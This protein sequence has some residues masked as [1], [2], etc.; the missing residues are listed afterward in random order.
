MRQAILKTSLVG[1][2]LA[3]LALPPPGFAEQQDEA[4]ARARPG[5][6]AAR[7]AP[8]TPIRTFRITAEDG[9]IVP[10]HIRAKVGER[11]RLIFRS[12]DGTYRVRFK[13]FDIKEKLIPGKLLVIHL[14][15]REKGEFSFGCTKSWGI[16][17]FSKNGVL[18]VK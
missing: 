11:I 16:K 5:T 1:L 3:A 9:E 18:V 4:R 10:A 6:V 15:P 2:A 12:E 8:A 13:D 14:T 17:H 7:S